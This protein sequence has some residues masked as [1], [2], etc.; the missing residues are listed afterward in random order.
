MLNF[1]TVCVILALLGV[2]LYLNA[3]SVYRPAPE[4][5]YDYR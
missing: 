3:V 5:D 2:D 1:L 4:P